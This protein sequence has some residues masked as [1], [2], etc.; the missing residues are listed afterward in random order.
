M[1]LCDDDFLCLTQAMAAIETLFLNCWIPRLEHKSLPHEYELCQNAICLNSIIENA[2]NV[3][4]RLLETLTTQ[5]LSTSNYR[6]HRI[7]RSRV[8]TPLKS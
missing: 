1:N 6:D 8:R 5:M 2:S 4:S 3:H 7:A